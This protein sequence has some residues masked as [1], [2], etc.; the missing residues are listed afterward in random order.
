MQLQSRESICKYSCNSKKSISKVYKQIVYFE[1]L[2]KFFSCT[3]RRHI[4][5]RF[6]LNSTSFG[7]NEFPTTSFWYT[8]KLILPKISTNLAFICKRYKWPGINKN[9]RKWTQQCI[10]CQRLKN[11]RHVVLIIETFAP[12][13]VRFDYVHVNLVGPL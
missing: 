1:T 4:M 6:N 9:V 10:S 13:D 11:H 5:R 7:T 2:K 12:P 3:W 8:T